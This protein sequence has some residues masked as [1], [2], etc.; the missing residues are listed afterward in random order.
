MYYY[1][2]PAHK[3]KALELDKCFDALP[4]KLLPPHTEGSPDPSQDWF[5]EP[6]THQLTKIASATPCVK[7]FPPKYQLDSGKWFSVD[8]QIRAA[9]RPR[10]AQR[11]RAVEHSLSR[12]ID[13]SQGGIYEDSE[14]K[15]LEV[16]IGMPHAR[17]AIGN[18]LGNQV[19]GFNPRDS[20]LSPGQM[21]PY[22][23]P[24]TW[25]S[26]FTAKV[27]RFLEL[28]GEGA[29]ITFSLFFFARLISNLFHWIFAG[30]QIHTA[31]GCTVGLLWM[32]CP[33]L[34]LMKQ[35]AGARADSGF[36]T[37]TPA[38]QRN[39]GTPEHYSMSL[40]GRGHAPSTRRQE[41]EPDDSGFEPIPPAATAGAHSTEAPDRE[42]NPPSDYRPHPC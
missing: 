12:D 36:S 7:A 27:V 29:A 2:C 39:D 5:M 20:T 16:Y 15:K 21:F 33:T 8:P 10:P 40:F 22:Q 37:Q 31:Q 19:R 1:K 34:F 28:W 11:T 32:L 25:F 26:D 6:L 9:P 18:A 13:P 17:R 30:K 41:T 23:T 4:V 14:L 42:T 38:G 3:V 35:F 24:S